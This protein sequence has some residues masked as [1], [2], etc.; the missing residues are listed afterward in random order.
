[1]S[2]I[3][4]KLIHESLNN[5]V[6]KSMVI[7]E[8]NVLVSNELQ[9]HIDNN[10]TLSENVF[11]TNSDKYFNLIN[12]VRHL[13]NQGLIELNEDDRWMIG[14]NLGEKVRLSNGQEVWLDAPMTEDEEFITEAKHKGKNVQLNH[15]VRNSGGGKKYSVYVKNPS[16]GN[17]KKISFGDV[18]G[19]LTAKVSNAKARKSFAARHQCD[20]KTDKTKAGYWACRINRYGY[21]WGGKT[22]P[23]YW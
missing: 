2:N 11:R 18:H 16:T 23:G 12:E 5:M 22:Y 17:I 8:S 9:Y 4:K 14:T 13:Y 7:T 10:L 6:N 21:L 15:P 1:M 3:I 20:K 19:G